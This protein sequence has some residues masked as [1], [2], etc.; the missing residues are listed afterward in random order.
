D[1]THQLNILMA[2]AGLVLLI[3][4][5]N[6]ANLLLA[7]ATARQREVGV[8]LSI[9]ASR[10]RLFR[11]F[12]TESVLLSLLGGLAGLLLAMSGARLLVRLISDPEQPLSLT[13]ELD[14]RVLVFTFGVTV[15]IGILFGLVPALRAS[16]TNLNLTL[17]ETGPG[18]TQS[19][20]RLNLAKSLVTM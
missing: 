4:C 9:G 15:F 1:F 18:T 16:R 7:R 13:P 17:R 19:S 2:V 10:A 14:W 12:L 20:G 5:A 6:I 11:Q 3:A 8:R